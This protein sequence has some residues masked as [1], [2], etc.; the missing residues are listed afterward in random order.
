[1]LATRIVFRTFRAA[2]LLA[3]LTV[4]VLVVT[5]ISLAADVTDI[6]YVDQAAIAAMP[7][8]VAANRNLTE[9]KAQLDKQFAAQMRGVKDTNVQA[10]IAQEFRNKLGVR[11]RDVI[12]PL[13]QRAQVAIAAVASNRNLSV[14]VD[15]RIVILGGQD[16]TKGVVDLLN[17]PGDPVPPVTTPPPSNVGYVD[18]QQID[19]VPK[20]K[21]ANDA[22]VKFE[23]DQE[24]AVQQKLR[25]VRA[26][27]DREQI[28][29]DM[30]K[31]ITDKQK[32]LI[33]PLVDQTRDVIAGIAKKRG[34]LLVIDRADLIYG[35]TD[36]TSDVAAALK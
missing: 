34:L 22:F 31:A 26:A 33:T 9:Y 27:G 11:Q 16:I 23:N 30:R 24:S 29:K 17:G 15:K 36:I 19:A 10:R 6:G 18:Q 21:A 2:A 13:L 12:E 8:F 7:A 14:V 28:L 5:S 25:G 20:I 4:A 1:M 32:E 3:A 35:G